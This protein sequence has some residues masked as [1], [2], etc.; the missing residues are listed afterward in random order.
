MARGDRRH[1]GKRRRGGGCAAFLVL[2]VLVLVA[3]GVA[4]WHYDVADRVWPREQPDPVAEP[5]VIAPP[6]GLELPEPAVAQVVADPVAPALAGGVRVA[7]VRRALAAG[8][9]DRALGRHV[10]VS[11]GSLD[12]EGPTYRSGRGAV[13]PASTL[14]LLTATSVLSALGPDHRFTTSVVRG[15]GNRVI[16][17]GGGDP[18]LAS[19]PVAP[20]ERDSVWPERADVRTLAR[21]VAT[22]LREAGTTRVRVGFDDSLF[23]GPAVNPTWEPG[24]VPDDVV[25]PV[26]A[27]WVD[28]GRDPSGYGRVDDPAATAADVFARALAARGVTVVGSPRRT[29]AEAD[30]A[31]LGSVRSAPLADIVERV[32]EVSDNDGAEVLARHVGAAVAHDAS[33]RGAV[34][35]MRTVLRGLGVDT[36]GDRWFDGSGLSRSNRVSVETIADVLRTAALG[37]HPELRPVLSGLPVA[38]FNGSLAYRFTDEGVPGLGRVRAKTGT[39]V[40]GGVHGL[41]G[42]VTDRTGGVLVFVGVA[43]R[44]TEANALPAREALDDVTAA[45]AAC[46]CS[47]R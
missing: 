2:L 21:Q 9:R 16:L 24:Y 10:V 36:T 45:L 29:R 20:R 32:L 5:A 15:A 1:P 18:H 40:E 27:L 38:G 47:T 26:S 19:A 34:R 13:I 43:D 6:P 39:L 28:Q 14:K 33:F 30:A 11:V 3:A 31:E 42:L 22:S 23:T 41:A 17:V 12:G 8:L 46:A 4:V 37:S 25:S 35:G 44:V 7:A